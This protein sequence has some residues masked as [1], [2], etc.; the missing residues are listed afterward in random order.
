MF[1]FYHLY[2]IRLQRAYKIIFYICVN[3]RKS[4]PNWPVTNTLVWEA[5]AK[6][7]RPILRKS[8]PVSFWLHREGDMASG[9]SWSPN[10]QYKLQQRRYLEFLLFRYDGPFSW[11]SHP[12]EM[13]QNVAVSQ[14]FLS[15]LLLAFFN[16]ESALISTSLKWFRSPPLFDINNLIFWCDIQ[17]EAYRQLWLSVK[18]YR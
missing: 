16:C 4:T 15:L 3:V 8:V 10:K 14:S 11:L 5:S 7:Q 17:H 9:H 12:P 1:T 6:C 18:H 13:V 2:W